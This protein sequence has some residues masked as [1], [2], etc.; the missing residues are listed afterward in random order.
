MAKEDVLS[1]QKTVE[2]NIPFLK[3]CLMVAFW[4]GNGIYLPKNLN[5]YDKDILAMIKSLNYRFV[6][7]KD[8][9]VG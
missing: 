2:Q 1:N 3:K 8:Y 6:L 9:F 4:N 5:F 7:N